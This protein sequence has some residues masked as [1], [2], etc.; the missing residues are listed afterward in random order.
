MSEPWLAA[1]QGPVPGDRGAASARRRSRRD[2]EALKRDI[3]AL[4][5]RVDAALT[6]LGQ[7]KE[8]IRGLVER[9]KQGAAAEVGHGAAVHRRP[10][11]GARRPPRAPRPTSRRAGA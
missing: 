2:R 4:F 10:P 3:I 5:K 8:D 1:L 9:Y 6:D 11:G 7:M